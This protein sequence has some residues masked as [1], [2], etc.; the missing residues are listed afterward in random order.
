MKKR[1]QKLWQL[2]KK[3][4]FF[5]VTALLIALVTAMAVQ[6][7]MPTDIFYSIKVGE[8]ISQHGIDM[9]DHFSI[10][11]NLPYTYPHWLFDYA[12]YWLYHLFGFSGIY[13]A[14]CITAIALMVMV[15]A[16]SY[17]LSPNKSKLVA[18]IITF[19]ATII[20]NPF[21]V[22][23]AQMVTYV[24]L[25][26]AVYLIER[27]LQQK[28]L[29]YAIGLVVIPWLIA[30]YHVAVYPF[31]L[32][33]FLPYVG[34]YIIGLIVRKIKRSKTSKFN[35]GRLSI[36]VHDN[37]KY[38]FV[39]M[40]LSSLVGLLTPLGLTPYTY[41]V[42]TMMGSSMTYIIEHMPLVLALSPE[43][44]ISMFA[45]I[46]FLVF[47]KIKLRLC[48]VF[49]LIGYTYLAL[50]TRRQEALLIIFGAII[51]CR[52]LSQFLASRADNF[53]KINQEI[54]TII[55]KPLFISAI[56]VFVFG[57]VLS[58]LL[59]KNITKS[60][61]NTSY[62]PVKVANYIVENLDTKKIRLYNQYNYGGYLLFRNIPVFI[63]P[64]ADLYT[65][66]FNGKHDIF[67]DYTKTDNI[68]KV[69]F[70]KTFHKYH[71]THVLVLESSHINT[72]IAGQGKSSNYKQLTKGDGYVLYERI[73]DLD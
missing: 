69:Y 70:E 9:K 49:A 14:T 18:F 24:L 11:S 30:N 73:K 50:A 68:D 53:D 60:L 27:F 38:L 61:G 62:Y 31:Y 5:I 20:M 47:T 4:S 22:P 26:L 12:I 21:F 28:K 39:I 3:H 41:L 67:N 64:R 42:K 29:S 59:A 48:D 7:V 56:A 58:P 52:L 40:G 36:A 16:I 10:H 37:A 54:E 72:V 57:L 63:D 45:V 13:I 46:V 55:F 43:I 51:V 1:I 44:L 19:V 71:I 32:V 65:K 17:K 34:E 2:I 6:S 25:L 15:Y 23:R 33:I 8:W 35:L 66:P